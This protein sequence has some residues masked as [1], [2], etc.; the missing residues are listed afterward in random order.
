MVPDNLLIC[1]SQ[2]I[3]V[4]LKDWQISLI[5]RQLTED[6]SMRGMLATLGIEKGKEF[7]PDAEMKKILTAGADVGM[8][9]AQSLRFGDKMPDTKYWPDRQWNNVLNV[10]DVEF[11][12]ESFT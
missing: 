7:A 4:I 3:I 8:K 11:K 9:M 6:W 10:L 2:E 1:F 5:M 12:E